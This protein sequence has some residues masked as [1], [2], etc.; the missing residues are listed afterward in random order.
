[1]FLLSKH[2][3]RF[4]KFGFG[5]PTSFLAAILV[6]ACGGG[7]GDTLS[8]GGS[9]ST[10]VAT[11]IAEVQPDNDTDTSSVFVQLGNTNT[12]STGVR[13]ASDVSR[14]QLQNQFL[15]DLE[16]ATKPKV[17]LGVSTSAPCDVTGFAQQLENAHKFNT[18][19][20]VRLD[21]TACQLNLLKSLPAVTGVYPDITLEHQAISVAPLLAMKSLNESVNFSFNGTASRQIN[22]ITN[23]V[24]S[25]DGNG[26]VIALLDTGV[27][28]RH[29]A[30]GKTKVLPGACFSTGS[31]GGASF[32][33]TKSQEVEDPNN[34]DDS[35]KVA[36]SCADATNSNVA[37][38]SSRA[39]G[40]SA[41]CQHGTAMASAAT[42][43]AWRSAS[44]GNV[45]AN[46]GI[47][48]QAKILPVQVFNKSGDTISAS[49]G[50]L[51]AALEWVLGEADR[52]KK[53]GLPPIVAVN[54]SLGGG[55]FTQ[56]C[57]NDF[58]GGKFYDV[59]SKLKIL[60]VLPVV[61]AGNS[62]TKTAITFP[63]CASNA[64]SVAA[65]QLDGQSPAS[66]SNFSSQVK[67]FAIGGDTYA[68]GMYA[69]PTL[70]SDANTFDC[71]ATMAGTSPAT[72]LVS[73]GVAALTS[74]KPS[75]TS[76]EIESALTSTSGGSSK[77]VSINGNTLS[78][79]R[80]TSSGYKLLG[81]TE[82]SPISNV[83]NPTPIPIT[84]AQGRVC[85]YPK[86][87]YQGNRSC[88]TFNYENWNR[89]YKLGFRVGSV[90]VE[91]VGGNA[92]TTSVTVTYFHSSSDFSNNVAG[93]S[94][95]GNVSSTA[96]FFSWDFRDLWY[97]RDFVLGV[98]LIYGVRVQS[99]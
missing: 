72:A 94:K 21:L 84:A 9:P 32:C 19:A 35:K 56:S 86:T 68:N 26:V 6:S 16:A 3:A 55:S 81:A 23:S 37:V 79:L 83:P 80:L 74:L 62:G 52:R 66:Y 18:D 30:L 92:P 38:W 5:G 61:A 22:T 82:Q 36:R 60:G 89:T 58:L 27:E 4:F 99:P 57:D 95:S 29:P 97:L 15:A 39:V 17:L 71:W 14:E 88:V 48:P 45:E 50:D 53:N 77:A 63:A 87:N 33:P 76:F 51:L 1:M 70:C 49:S 25:A 78:A 43:G 13:V 34:T 11:Q 28:E 93:V 91:P 59:F 20:V 85:F 47:A 98:P 10:Q 54:L 41:G 31:N 46:G 12:P 96:S 90:K 8:M 44:T 67:L 42:M 73:G 75:S 65:T 64:L 40:V 69:L 2:V 24:K 7:G